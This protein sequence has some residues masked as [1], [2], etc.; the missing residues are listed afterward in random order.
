MFF[1][2]QLTMILPDEI[3]LNPFRSSLVPNEAANAFAGLDP[4]ERSTNVQKLLD[5]RVFHQWSIFLG[6]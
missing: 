2:D 5:M 6:A 1:I 3:R 4:R